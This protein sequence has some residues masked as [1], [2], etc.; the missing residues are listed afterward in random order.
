VR[1]AERRLGD[2]ERG[3][4]A[5]GRE[6]CRAEASRRC[7][8]PAGGGVR[9]IAGACR[10]VD[11]GFSP[12]GRLTVDVGEPR[13][14]LRAAVLRRATAQQLG[15]LVDERRADVAGDERGVVQHRL[16]EGDVGRDAADAELGE[17]AARARPRRR[18]R[19]RGR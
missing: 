4:L 10:R 11:S 1:V 3:L 12:C 2:G 15:A 13:D 5:Q 8:E 14:D 16:Q 7:R 18:S 19:V 9:S 6:P 17:G